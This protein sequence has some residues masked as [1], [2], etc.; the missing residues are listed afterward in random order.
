MRKMN[1]V[2]AALSV[3][4]LCS[5]AMAGHTLPELNIW[6]GTPTVNG[7]NATSANGGSNLVNPGVVVNIGDTVSFPMYGQVL[8][9]DFAQ[10]M[11]SFAWDVWQVGGNVAFSSTATADFYAANTGTPGLIAGP[12]AAGTL[13]ASATAPGTQLSKDYSISQAL[14]T[15][16]NTPITAASGVFFMGYLT[17]TATSAGTTDLYYSNSHNPAFSYAYSGGTVNQKTIAYGADPGDLGGDTFADGLNGTQFVNAGL[18]VR[19]TE[20]GMASSIA[21]ASITVIPE[22]GTLALLGLGVLALRRRRA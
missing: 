18:D 21:D 5:T 9:G 12:G 10:S 20:A 2:M 19:G 15:P 7:G 3:V 11:S 22:P 13:A 16:G 4:A 1:P 8:A 17:V 6:F 14:G